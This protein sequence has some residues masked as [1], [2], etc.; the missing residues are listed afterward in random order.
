MGVVTDRCRPSPLAEV[1][2]R[3]DARP[4]LD[5]G[6]LWASGPSNMAGNKWD[7]VSRSYVG[8][9]ASGGVAVPAAA[10]LLV[11]RR[12]AFGRSGSG[13]RDRRGRKSS[14]SASTT[15]SP[16]R[17]A[18]MRMKARTAGRSNEPYGPPSTVKTSVSPIR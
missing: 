12:G 2:V 18:K 11:R 7:L 10:R 5:A 6:M 15:I 14:D 16:R 8:A 13:S 4:C 9:G 17:G 1:V 3:I